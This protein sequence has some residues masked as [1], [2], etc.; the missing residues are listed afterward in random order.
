MKKINITYNPYLIKTS[1][2]IEGKTPKPN[3]RLN[4]GKIRLQEWANNIADILVEESRDKNFQ[5]EFVGLETDFE[6][7]R[8]LFLRQKMSQYRSFSRKN[9]LLKRSSMR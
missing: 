9:L 5:I 2:L 8:L 4:F 1:V 6:D 3:S 7:L